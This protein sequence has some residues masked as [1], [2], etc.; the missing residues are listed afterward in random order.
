MKFFQQI[1][2]LCR[3][4]NWSWG[5]NRFALV[6]HSKQFLLLRSNLTVLFLETCCLADFWLWRLMASFFAETQSLEIYRLTCLKIFWK[7]LYNPL[8]R[9]FSPL[10]SPGAS[11]KSSKRGQFWVLIFNAWYLTNTLHPK[12]LKPVILWCRRLNS[13]S[14]RSGALFFPVN[15]VK[16]WHTPWE[17]L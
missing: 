15:N 11:A 17:I 9:N 14:N 8:K 6:F 12:I 2:Q 4:C 5:C 16:S 7:P 3:T 13:S 10:V 1:P